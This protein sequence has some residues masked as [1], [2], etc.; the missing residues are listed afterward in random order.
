MAEETS[1]DKVEDDITPEEL[2]LVQKMFGGETGETG[3]PEP[4][5][6]EG[7]VKFFRDILNL[8]DEHEKINRTG[9]LKEEELGMLPIS[10]RAYN[11]I[12]TYADTE[13][14]TAV[15]SYLRGKSNIVMSTSLS[16]KAKFLELFV[17]Q[18]KVSRTLG[19]P[20]RE[21]HKKMFGGETIK[22]EG[23]EDV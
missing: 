5:T 1:T 23:V 20:K 4:P 15:A 22:E 3:F 9:N 11:D 2:A 16:R 13:K 6:K 19:A 7:M 21:V 18:R 14:L 17:T 8:V 12:A 10:A